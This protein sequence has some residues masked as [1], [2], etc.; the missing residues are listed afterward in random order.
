[1]TV[2]TKSYENISNKF[3]APYLRKTI[4]S[5]QDL[6]NVLAGVG[7]W[8]A[9]FTESRIGTMIIIVIPP[10][11]PRP[12]RER[13]IEALHHTMPAYVQFIVTTKKQDWLKNRKKYCYRWR[14]V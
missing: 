14:L 4:E 10:T 11:C 8:R 1:M 12:N 9:D 13:L 5:H 6:Y 2:M 3:I 7:V